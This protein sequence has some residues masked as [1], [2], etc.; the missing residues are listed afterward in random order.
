[1]QD[2]Q[3]GHPGAEAVDVEVALSDGT[4]PL[5]TQFAGSALHCAKSRATMEGRGQRKIA[6]I[7]N[8][9]EAALITAA[10]AAARYKKRQQFSLGPKPIG[11]E[12]MVCDTSFS[13]KALILW[14]TWICPC[15]GRC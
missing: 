10:M 15:E 9:N 3:D 5:L 1:M 12:G 13:R 14:L 11:R 6:A 8:G 4:L 7:Y 2:D